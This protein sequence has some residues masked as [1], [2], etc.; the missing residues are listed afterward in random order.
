MNSL[1]VRLA[2]LSAVLMV[3]GVGIWEAWEWAM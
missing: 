1:T 3:I 2:T